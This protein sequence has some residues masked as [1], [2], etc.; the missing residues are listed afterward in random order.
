[1]LGKKSNKT[2]VEER[3]QVQSLIDNLQ[4]FY[5][6]KSCDEY[7]IKGDITKSPCYDELET[8]LASLTTIKKY[9]VEEAKALKNIFNILHRP[10]FAKMTAE[11][12]K[13]PTE[14]NIIFTAVFTVGY[15]LL[16]GE[17]SRVV[18]SSEAT[19]KGFVYKPDKISRKESYSKLVRYFNKD[20]ESRIDSVI[21]KSNNNK[22]LALQES[23]VTDVAN[24]AVGLVEGVFGIFN[25]I[26]SSAAALNPI[27]LMSAI[28]S[29]SYDKKVEKYEKIAK[30]YEMTKKA[31][32]E[33]QKIPP[34]NRKERVG[35]RYVKMIESY[36]IKMEKLKK[37]IEHFDM[38]AQEEVGEHRKALANSSPKTSPNVPK[39]DDD[40]KQS[41]DDD[42]GSGF[43]F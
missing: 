28:L 35:H 18:T 27:A 20:L 40:K 37:E 7:K 13:E 14:A 19:D 32:D 6:N 25:K 39:S 24:I 16:V 5:T 33:W 12:M 29:R 11:Y 17:V 1:M 31:Y 10:R 9:P 3:A 2:I 4:R 21:R 22:L 36:N 30:E 34:T 15:R 23:A 42:G 8:D 38:R 43:S 41:T 26:F